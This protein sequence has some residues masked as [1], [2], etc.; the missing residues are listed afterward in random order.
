MLPQH[1]HRDE[2]LCQYK[3]PVY[4]VGGAPKWQELMC[5]IVSQ[6]HESAVKNSTNV[7]NVTETGCFSSF[8]VMKPTCPINGNVSHTSIDPVCSGCALR[9]NNQC[10]I[11]EY[12]RLLTQRSTSRNGA[13]LEET[14]ECRVVF[15]SQD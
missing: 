9:I 12:V 11:H 5:R 13:E 8:C 10:W 3:V 15:A 4:E 14:V 7:I 6:L 1:R 2:N